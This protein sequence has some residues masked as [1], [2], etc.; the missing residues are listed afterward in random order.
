VKDC[1]E[2]V[3]DCKGVVKDSKGVVKDC[4]EVVKDCKQSLRGW[5]GPCDCYGLPLGHRGC[6]KCKLTATR[7]AS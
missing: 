2:V 1:N 7:S 5:R 3:K 4:K 6:R